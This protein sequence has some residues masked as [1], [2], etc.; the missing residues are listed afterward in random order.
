LSAFGHSLSFSRLDL[1]IG[2][3]LAH[4]VPNHRAFVLNVFFLLALLYFEEW[5]LRDEY[6]AQLDQLRHLPKEESKE[7]GANVRAVHVGI[8]HQNDFMITKLADIKILFADPGA[9]RH[10]QRFNI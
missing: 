2:R 8:G 4:Q 5:W 10:D 7:Q 3:R 9:E 1:H 6:V